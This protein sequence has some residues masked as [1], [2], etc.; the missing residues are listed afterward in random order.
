MKKLFIFLLTFSLSLSAIANNDMLKVSQKT[1]FTKKGEPIPYIEI[2]LKD[3]LEIK[4]VV[5]NR[6]NCT[7][8]VH[9]KEEWSGKYQ[10]LKDILWVYNISTGVSMGANIPVKGKYGQ[11]ITFSS[12]DCSNLLELQIETDKGTLTYEF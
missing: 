12:G 3:D 11:R 2:V 4:K 9:T 1:A 10:K 8:L 6:G 7:P 5:A